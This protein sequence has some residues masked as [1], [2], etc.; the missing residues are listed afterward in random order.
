[1]ECKY[2]LCSMDIPYGDGYFHFYGCTKNGQA[3]ITT[4][5]IFKLDT[6]KWCPEKKH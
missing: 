5:V 1:M 4:K 6:P 3:V 2:F